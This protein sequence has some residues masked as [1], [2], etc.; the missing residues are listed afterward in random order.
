MEERK[1][2]MRDKIRQNELDAER[3]SLLDDFEQYSEAS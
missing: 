1:Q 3:G 2:L